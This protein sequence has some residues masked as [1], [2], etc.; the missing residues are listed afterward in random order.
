MNESIES[1]KHCKQL[2]EL[3]FGYC[4][5]EEDLFTNINAI[6][7][8]LQIIQIRTEKPFS[9]SFI[10]SF[11]SMKNIQKVYHCVYG[12]PEDNIYRKYWF[13]G[14]SLSEVML[15]P[16]GKHV[17]RV[18]DICGSITCKGYEIKIYHSGKLML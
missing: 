3:D 9:D 18:N 2:N 15:S 5:I 13:F 12:L 6:L 1:L 16:N 14:K 10:D 8:K 17:I 11:H 4:K 7:P